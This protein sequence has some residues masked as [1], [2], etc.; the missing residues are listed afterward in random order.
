MNLIHKET[1]DLVFLCKASEY[2]LP[3][4]SCCA[5][6]LAEEDQVLAT[7]HL[8]FGQWNSLSIAVKPHNLT[9]H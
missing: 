9:S 2:P 3:L 5:L 1:L 8:F 4:I 6:G 7:D